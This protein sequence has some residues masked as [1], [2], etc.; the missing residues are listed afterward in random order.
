[1]D[2]GTSSSIA[3][4]IERVDPSCAR[5][6]GSHGRVDAALCV[7]HAVGSRWRDVHVQDGIIIDAG[8]RYFASHHGCKNKELQHAM[9][10]SV[11]GL[12]GM[13]LTRL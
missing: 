5:S 11:L 7:P 3:T 1:M 12:M 4:L 13:A 2:S 9:P 8:K 10:T 6:Y